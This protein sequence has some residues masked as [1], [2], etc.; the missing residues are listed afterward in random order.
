MKT[1][2]QLYG[3]IFGSAIVFPMAGGGVIVSAFASL[4]QAA[5]RDRSIDS[6]IIV[7]IS[8]SVATM[9]GSL[10]SLGLTA[11]NVASPGNSVFRINAAIVALTGILSS[12]SAGILL[13]NANKGSWVFYVLLAGGLAILVSGIAQFIENK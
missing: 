9:I 12:A 4:L 1:A 13:S 10:A 5:M 8:L 11:F 2:V 6:E 7:M 3:G